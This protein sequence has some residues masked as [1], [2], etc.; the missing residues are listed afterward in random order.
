MWLV[1]KAYK[2]RVYPDDEQIV[3]ISKTLGCCRWVYNHFLTVRKDE[4]ETNK[5]SVSYNDCSKQLTTLKTEENTIWLKE[6]DATALQSSLKNLDKAYD[7]FFKGCKSGKQVGYPE[8]KC[9]HDHNQS[10]TSK[11]NGSI[12]LGDGC[13]FMPKLGWL[14]CKISKQ[15]EG[16]IISATL[17]RNAAGR[18]YIS[19]C[20]TDVEIKSLPKTNKQVGIDLGISSY[21]A[22]S[23]GDKFDNPKYLSKAEKR[24]K[25]LQRQ[26][27]RKQKDS[28]NRNKCRQILAK[29]HEKVANQRNDNINKLTTMLIR[30][31]DTICIEDLSVKNM[32]KNH[33]LAKVINDAAWGEFK[34]QLLYKAEWYGKNIIVIDRYF[35]SSQTCSH[36]NSKWS[37]TK[38]LKIRDWVCPTC[39]TH[40][41][42]DINAAINILNFGLN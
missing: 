24:L 20:C 36:C 30:N 23:D 41:D 33:H 3:L 14:K 35:A 18:Y 19:M 11:N 15:V 4:Y 21:I 39:G 40:H 13:V 32:V 22:T 31:Y 37:G 27:S 34:R 12:K 42:R 29:A 1:D 5:K 38:N 16:R 9:K 2:F 25:R 6:V 7:N 8:Y 10:F 26:L 17:R 28:N